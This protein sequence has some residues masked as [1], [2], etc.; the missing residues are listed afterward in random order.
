MKGCAIIVIT[1][2]IIV[3]LAFTVGMLGL[4]AGLLGSI[5]WFGLQLLVKIVMIVL[6]VLGVWVLV[7]FVP[8][9]DHDGTWHRIG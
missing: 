1:I 5:L 2:G 4:L 6:I 7:R 9:K 8:H 3:I